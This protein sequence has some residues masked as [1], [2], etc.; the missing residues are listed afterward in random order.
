MKAQFISPTF[1]KSSTTVIN[2]VCLGSVLLMGAIALSA[3]GDQSPSS[4]EETTSPEV[5]TPAAEETAEP[6]S[7]DASEMDSSEETSASE[8]M[9]TASAMTAVNIGKFTSDE[10]FEAGGGGCGMSLNTVDG[11]W[12]EGGLFF[13]GIEDEPAFMKIDGNLVQLTRTAAQ[14]ESFYGQR[15]E[16]TFTNSD[17]TFLVEVMV[18]L[19]EP[20]EIE[21]VTIPEGMMMIDQGGTQVEFP[22]EGDAGC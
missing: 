13:H 5:S 17:G 22:V 4:S 11:N 3:C 14:G 9:T 21:S 1:L 2:A 20:G 19:G 18:T 7:T 16:Q 6:S 10:L 12:Q 8:T 15:T